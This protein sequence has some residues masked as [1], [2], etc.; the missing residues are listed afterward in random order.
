M[1]TH[2]VII[3]DEILIGQVADTNSAWI[4]SY[5]NRKGIR[6]NGIS[7]VGDA[8]GIIAAAVKNALG[9]NDLVILTGGLGPTK[10]DVTKEALV[11]I[12]GGKLTLHRPT[13]DFIKELLARRN[14]DFNGLNERQ[15]YVS[16]RCEVLPNKH[17]TAPGMWF[18]ADG[19]VLVSLPGVPF[20]M[21]ELMKN[22][23]FPRIEKRFRVKSVLHKTVLTYGMPE[24]MMAQTIGPWE[25]ALPGWMRLAYLPNPDGIR[26]RISAY[27][28]DENALVEIDSQFDKLA[29]IIPDAVV[30]GAVD[31]GEPMSLPKVVAAMLTGRKET[32]SAAESCTG[33]A[34]STAFTASAGASDFFL[35]SVVSYS[36]KMK[37]E[38][39]GVNASD[40]A[41]Y[42]A[43]SQTVAEQMAEGVRRLTGSTYALATTGIA[44][45]TGGS[46]EKPVGTV[47]MAVATPTGC[48]SMKK[49]FGELRQQ[50]IA[51]ATSCVIN[52]LRLHLVKSQR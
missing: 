36:N 45:P 15:A 12:F 13:Y 42:G 24:S 23:V 38:I 27:E 4:A 48:Y 7:T 40:I 2:I 39:L 47:W 19:K 37:S 20:E 41:E 52:M 43:V 25:D 18:E 34:V 11:E 49:V 50:N 14:I 3:G 33:G 51:R 30:S 29:A 9:E 1:N 28:A 44:G 35:G 16:E 26:L 31:N 8:K 5:L 46:P 32:L 10:D 17:G 21:E 6:V 22:E